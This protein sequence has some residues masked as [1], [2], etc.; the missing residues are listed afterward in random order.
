MG[1][2]LMKMSDI[3][4]IG[5]PYT[6]EG[7]FTTV[8]IRCRMCDKAQTV[9]LVGCNPVMC[10]NCNTVFQCVELA[11]NLQFMDQ[12]RINIGVQKAVK[13]SE[14]ENVQN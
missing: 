12:T 1:T 5:Q 3:P 7:W 6:L 13:I 14:G 10:P 4:V 11:F 9:M 8:V 2:P